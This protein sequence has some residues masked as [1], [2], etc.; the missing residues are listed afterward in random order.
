MSN[1]YTLSAIFGRDLKTPKALNE[2]LSHMVDVI[3]GYVLRD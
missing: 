1:N 2:R 3:L